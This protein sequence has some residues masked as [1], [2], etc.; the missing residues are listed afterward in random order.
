[1]IVETV[2]YAR[3]TAFTFADGIVVRVRRNGC[4]AGNLYD[5]EQMATQAY[6]IRAMESSETR[7]LAE[8]ISTMSHKVNVLLRFAKLIEVGNGPLA[9]A[10]SATNY[11]TA[12]HM[13]K[14]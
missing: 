14:K 13:P 9:E 2:E 8:T 5:M 11:A 1:M 4:R 3:Y 12:A 7:E 10:I 6:M